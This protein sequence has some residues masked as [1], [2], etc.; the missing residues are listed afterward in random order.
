MLVSR[1]SLRLTVFVN[2]SCQFT[3]I[4][5]GVSLT[6]FTDK[7]HLFL[8]KG[9]VNEVT[10]LG[11]QIDTVSQVHRLQVLVFNTEEIIIRQFFVSFVETLGETRIPLLHLL[12]NT[13][14][15]NDIDKGV[16]NI[17]RWV[18]VRSVEC[19]SNFVTNQH[20]IDTVGCTFPLR[21]CQNT[22]I[23]VKLS[24]LYISVLNHNVLSG[25]KLGQL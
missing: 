16:G 20:V 6:Y 13:G 21:E 17:F 19:V 18:Y 22:G 2:V 7:L 10:N 14:I 5:K 11:V 4:L 3:N 1:G 9:K 12:L 8:S 15:L 23:N 25:E 24:R